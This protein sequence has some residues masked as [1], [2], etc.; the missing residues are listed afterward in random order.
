MNSPSMRSPARLAYP[1]DFSL[2]Q[3]LIRVEI[4]P[5]DGTIWAVDWTVQLKQHHRPP[6][7]GEA[8]TVPVIKALMNALI[9]LNA[10]PGFDAIVAKPRTIRNQPRANGKFAKG[11]Q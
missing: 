11:K 6:T 4:D 8:I 7:L 2:V 9:G 1:K 10:L 5:A 3:D